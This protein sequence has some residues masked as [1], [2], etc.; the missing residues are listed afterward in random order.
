M[1]L[2]GSAGITLVLPFYN[3]KKM[4]VI[5]IFVVFNELC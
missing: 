5:I 2:L 3:I 4:L 1:N